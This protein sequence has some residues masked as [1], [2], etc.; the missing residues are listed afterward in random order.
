[1]EKES[2]RTLTKTPSATHSAPDFRQQG[3]SVS[4]WAK[5]RGFSARLVYVILRGE[6]KCLRGESFKIAK[7][8][9]MK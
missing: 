7:E 4:D 2:E 8:L 3:L 6:R 9:G 5:A 1:M